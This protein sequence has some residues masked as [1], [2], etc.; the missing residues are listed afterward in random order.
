MFGWEDTLEY[1]K[2]ILIVFI[3]SYFNHGLIGRQYIVQLP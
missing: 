2:K 3:L 1:P